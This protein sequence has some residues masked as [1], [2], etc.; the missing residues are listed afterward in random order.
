MAV[1]LS[2]D[3]CSV[4]PCGSGRYDVP[5]INKRAFEISSYIQQVDPILM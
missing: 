1:G 5:P 3:V 2:I 4:R